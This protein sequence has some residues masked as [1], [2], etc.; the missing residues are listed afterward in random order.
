MNVVDVYASSRVWGVLLAAVVLAV[1][2]FL[3]WFIRFH[4]RVARWLGQP[5][6]TVAFTGL[7][8]TSVGD[9]IVTVF[10]TPEPL[11]PLLFIGFGVSVVAYLLTER[12]ALESW[13]QRQ[14]AET[15]ALA[16]QRRAILADLDK[17]TQSWK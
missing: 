8:C 17:I 9:L 13:S 14:Q 7:V 6:I 11:R 4:S 1:V 10:P 3:V 15:A 5:V 16:D 12:R 2:C